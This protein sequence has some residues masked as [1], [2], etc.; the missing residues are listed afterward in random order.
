M[1]RASITF[2]KPLHPSDVMA[3]L[4]PAIHVFDAMQNHA[5]ARDKPGMTSKRNAMCFGSFREG[6]L[7][8]PAPYA[9]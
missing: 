2:L 6:P 1:E 5:D 8:N 4:D 7:L 9:R 3:G